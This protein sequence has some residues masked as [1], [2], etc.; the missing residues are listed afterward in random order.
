MS[1][2]LKR[3]ARMLLRRAPAFG[4]MID[5]VSFRTRYTDIAPQ[6]LTDVSE[7][8]GSAWKDPGVPAK[9]RRLVDEE[10]ASYRTGR[11]CP[12][13]DALV[14]ILRHNIPNL[15]GMTLLEVGCSTGYYGEVLQARGIHAEYR[16]CDFSQAFINLARKSYPSFG[17][18][19]EDATRLNYPD[20][21]FD[22]VVSG[23][24]LLHIRCYEEAIAE[25]ARVARQFAVFHRTPVLHMQGPLFYRKKA[26]GM[27]MLEIHFN[28]QQ[29]V[30]LFSAHRL[31]LVDINCH[32]VMAHRDIHDPLF[33]K[34]Y[35]CRKVK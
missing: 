3:I 34:S 19:V 10:L 28:E 9:Q 31:H 1:G 2:Q 8:L 25:A 17:F 5:R 11:P 15:D 7:R 23:C 14:E 12:S 26:Y 29:L 22:I 4:G 30:R 20:N 6:Q 33:H 27:E 13:F 32:A 16:G 24:C 21:S 18:D 35:L